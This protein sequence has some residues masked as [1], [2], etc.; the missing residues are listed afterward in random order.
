MRDLQLELDHDRSSRCLLNKE[1]QLVSSTYSTSMT[2]HDI[3]MTPP[4]RAYAHVEYISH[5]LLHFATLTCQTP[6]AAGCSKRSR[7]SDTQ[8][9]LV[10][11]LAPTVHRSVNRLI[12]VRRRVRKDSLVFKAKKGCFL[13]M[14]SLAFLGICRH[15][16]DRL[17]RERRNTH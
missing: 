9:D 10:C 17:R 12:D 13:F 4:S 8:R 7:A 3:C 5:T 15:G 11:R 6:H 16:C 2:P 14:S 1:T